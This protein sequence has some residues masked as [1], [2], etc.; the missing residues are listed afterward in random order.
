MV[1]ERLH[2]KSIG[3]V[4]ALK[5]PIKDESAT[6]LTELFD[7]PDIK[8]SITLIGTQPDRIDESTVNTLLECVLILL[9]SGGHV[10]EAIIIVQMAILLANALGNKVII[11][12]TLATAG[13]T[14]FKSGQFEKS[15]EYVEEAKE[16]Y[17]QLGLLT[18][19]QTMN[20]AATMCKDAI[21]KRTM[22]LEEKC[23][24][25]GYEFPLIDGEHI[26]VSRKPQTMQKAA[27]CYNCGIVVCFGC[28]VWRQ[29][30]RFIG[31]DDELSKNTKTPYCPLCEQVL[32]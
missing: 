5:T 7:L 9:E 10:H 20:N 1:V 8:D 32:G 6:F 28:A 4:I 22:R 25:C 31:Q 3:M 19:V 11:S 27:H 2:L 24:I 30:E 18:E 16:I 23:D 17:S 29:N 21:L 15:Q 12:E 14:F 26:V 13:W